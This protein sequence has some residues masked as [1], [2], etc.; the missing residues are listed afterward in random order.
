MAITW[1][2]HLAD[3][4][5]TIFTVAYNGTIT[6][7]D[8][9]HVTFS[10]AHASIVF[11]GAFTGAPASAG[12]VTGFKVYSSGVLALDASGYDMPFAALADAMAMALA[13]DDLL[14]SLLFADSM[15]IK[16]SP[17]DED[18]FGGAFNDKLL[19]GGGDD[20]LFG[21]GGDDL[22]K[23]G[24]GNDSLSG[25]DGKDTLKGGGGDDRL[26]GGPG[27]DKLVG[28]PGDDAFAFAAEF[29]KG[30]VDRIVKFKPGHDTIELYLEGVSFNEQ[31]AKGQFRRG[32]E[33]RDADDLVIYDRKSGTL[34]IDFDGK[35][36]EGQIKF[37]KVDPGLRLSHD[38]FWLM[39]LG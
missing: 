19:G 21:Y 18:L 26:F 15:V 3:Y 32:D 17:S 36:G 4:Y 30:D 14:V 37:A 9:T 39:A 16:G 7:S 13:D 31:L 5:S 29:L 1:N 28:G 20:D 12:A 8:G 2:I 6:Q 34:F 35:G 38:D 23:G 24:G 22:V 10:S 11:E 27:R 25:G 33:A